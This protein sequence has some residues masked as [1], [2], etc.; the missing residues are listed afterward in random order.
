MKAIT[1]A[2]SVFK[3]VFFRLPLAFSILFTAFS[4]FW[5]F[6]GFRRLKDL[7]AQ[8]LER[9]A[10]IFLK[11]ELPG[12]IANPLIG[13]MNE[14]FW[15]MLVII[16]FFSGLLV[17]YNLA[18]LVN[19]IVITLR[20]KPFSYPIGSPRLHREAS[21]ENNLFK[22]ARIGIVLAGGGAK[23]A[24]QA[25]AMKAIYNYLDKCNALEKIKVISGTS[26]GSWNGLFWLA[27]LIRTE[28]GGQGRGVHEG[29]W[30]NIS[31]K[32]LTAP[33]W[34]MPFCRNAFLSSKPWQQVFDHIFNRNDVKK[35]IIESGIH[36]YF[37][38]SNVR[39]GQLE[40]MTNNENPPKIARVSYDCLD[41]QGD[42]DAF[43][44]ALK[45]GVF[46]SMD[47]PPLFPFMEYNDNLFED[48]GV[49]DNLP[50]IFPA[51]EGCNLIFVLPLN[52]DFE[53]E[54]NET[55]VMARLFR[56][57]DIRQGALERNS[58]K[59][60]YLYNELAALRKC[61][62]EL[63]A[64]TCQ[65]PVSAHLSY[66]LER[67]HC[68]I[69]VFAVCPQ[70]SFVKSTINTQ[71]F[72]KQKEAGIA[73]DIMYQATTALLSNFEY[74]QHQDKIKVALIS[75]SGNVTWDEDF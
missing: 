41:K 75:R 18:A 57:M 70:K 2:V 21:T 42:Q 6:Y 47:I 60:Q 64:P 34:Y 73:F 15:A 59:I 65:K 27:D 29:W 1:S 50:I 53:E 25:G 54:P 71:E 7:L 48:G 13:N 17:S 58:F 66:A 9:A 22:E 10:T 37:T 4:L 16:L 5:V 56:V 35:R 55:S 63:A 68:P 8:P 11:S 3:W 40:C 69:S 26:I 39:S 72:W 46:A 32:S 31:A 28:T 12:I 23:G 49:I 20:L 62:D 43:L 67:K 30:R 44:A 24:F 51:M 61:I 38:R 36:F 45:N 19:W 74:G 33:S 52:S 14:L